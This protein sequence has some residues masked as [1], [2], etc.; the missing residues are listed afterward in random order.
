MNLLYILSL[1]HEIMSTFVWRSYPATYD[2]CGS[3]KVFMKGHWNNF[4]FMKP[5]LIQPSVEEEETCH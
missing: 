1:I 5:I 3:A 4:C 2:V